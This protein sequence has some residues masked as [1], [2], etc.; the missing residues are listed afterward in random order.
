MIMHIIR[1]VNIPDTMLEK[2]RAETL[3]DKD[4]QV[5]T[6]MITVGWPDS[7]SELPPSARPFFDFRETMSIENGLIMRGE[8]VLVPRSMRDEIKKKA[9]R[10]SLS[11]RQ[12]AKEGKKNSILARNGHRNKTNG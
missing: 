10:S 12:Y 8:K 9:T 11:S 7:K 5:L 2:L 6:E 3:K 1:K 4:M